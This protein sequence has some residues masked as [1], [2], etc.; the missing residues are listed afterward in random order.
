MVSAL[1][2]PEPVIDGL[3]SAHIVSPSL[4]P[5]SLSFLQFTLLRP[6]S[7]FAA[8]KAGLKS[9]KEQDFDKYD[10]GEEALSRLVGIQMREDINTPIR[11]LLNDV[12]IETFWTNVS[13]MCLKCD[14]KV[15]TGWTLVQNETK[16]CP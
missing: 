12:S 2:S 14:Q 6:I 10:Y 15:A 8:I 5:S 1:A 13:K 7:V 11:V 9:P 16:M 4:P 3:F